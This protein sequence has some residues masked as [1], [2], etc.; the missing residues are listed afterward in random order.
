MMVEEDYVELLKNLIEANSCVTRAIDGFWKAF[1]NYKTESPE[2]YMCIFGKGDEIIELHDRIVSLEIRGS[3]LD[4][5][6]YL[7]VAYSFY[8]KERYVGF[9]K[10]IFSLDGEI[11]ADEFSVD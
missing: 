1:S 3:S 11:I 7:F 4:S 10:M 2:E 8:R 6:V 9:Y 5:S